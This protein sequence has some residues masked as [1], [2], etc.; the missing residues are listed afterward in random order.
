MQIV[1]YYI[2]SGRKVPGDPAMVLAQTE[3]DLSIK[4]S[5]L[6]QK[7]IGSF[8]IDFSG[9]KMKIYD[10]GSGK[11]AFDELNRLRK[12]RDLNLEKIGKI[13]RFCQKYSEITSISEYQDKYSTLQNLEMLLESELTHL[14]D[15]ISRRYKN[16][17]ANYIKIGMDLSGDSAMPL[18]YYMRIGILNESGKCKN[19][20]QQIDNIGFET[21]GYL[22]NKDVITEYVNKI[23]GDE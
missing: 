5:E 13:E 7:C 21:K 15:K 3:K 18:E 23:C 17:S 8:A 6:L 2:S 12:I 16:Q 1:E 14:V 4:E 11:P 20:K 10:A 22:A 9:D 19:Y